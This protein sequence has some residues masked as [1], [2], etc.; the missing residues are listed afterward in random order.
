MTFFYYS[1]PRLRRAIAPLA[2]LA[3]LAPAGA[4]QAQTTTFSYT[5]GL[6]TYTVPAG[7]TSLRVVATGA[8]GGLFYDASI[9]SYSYGGRVQATVAVTPGEVLTVRVGGQGTTNDANGS[10]VFAGGFNGGGIGTDDGSGSNGGGGGGGGATD[11]RRTGASTGDYLASR[12]ALLVAGGGGGSSFGLA[13]GGNGGTP[14][15]NDGASDS[16]GGSPGRGATQ[17]AVGAGTNG[18]YSGS[19]GTGGAGGN[20]VGGYS[21]GGGGG[22]YYGGGGSSSY[23][24]TTYSD[25]A[26]GGGGSSWAMAGSNPA[27]GVAATAGPGTLTITVAALTRLS[28]TFGPVGTPVTL[29]G[30]GLAG[31][32]G[33]RFNGTAATTFA[34]ASSTSIT[35]TVPAGA[36][37]GNV[38]VS[39]PSGTSNGLYFTVG[40]ATNN[41][42]SFD[43]TNDYVHTPGLPATS[44]FTLEA[45][46]NQAALSGSRTSLLMSDNAIPGALYLQFDQNNRLEFT[47]SGNSNGLPLTSALPIGQWAHVAVVYSAS[48]KSAIIYVN[49]AVRSSSNFI[50]AVPVAAQ[51][52][53]LGAWLNNGTPER[54]FTGRFDEVRLYS[55]ALTRAQIQADMYST[56]S[57][58]PAS[59]LAYYSFNQGTAGG[60]NAG[61]AGLTDQSSNGNTA[62]LTNF[63]LTGTASNYVRSFPTI[64]AISPARAQPGATVTVTG[65]NLL[66]ATSFAFNGTA[67]APFA[68][69]TNDLSTTVTVP[70]GTTTGPVSLASATLST[71]QGP[72]FTVGAPLPV[73]LVAFTAEAAG[74]GALLRWHTATELNNARFEVEASAD[75]RAFARVGTVAGAG[76]STQAH[77]YTFG[78]A[79]LTRY[80]A[81]LVYYRLR[82]V[83][84]DGTAAYSPV[85][86][87]AV[88][89]G[90]LALYPNPAA[91]TTT[92]SGAAAS[93]PVRV[94]DALGRLVLTAIT[95]AAG[96]A[97]LTLPA[98]QPA[99]LYLVRAGTA[100]A[101]RLVVE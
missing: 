85:R 34:V 70:T 36:T 81:P 26:G 19:A 20:N 27:Y 17:A 53:S 84:T 43:G 45:W 6:Q 73:Q 32:T 46:V 21:G 93:T 40:T 42:L 96:M 55:A 74:T 38:T 31:V 5:G 58:V 78:D 10:T 63:A 92:L 76:S 67:V 22:G 82:Q 60:A 87:V 35:A 89:G 86:P 48:T 28:P 30:F 98:S 47:V 100:P 24:N 68:T 61:A 12:N 66:D 97:P 69:P 37:S 4:A 64:T 16:G 29:T 50:T 62:T 71:Y 9:S 52:V 59:L 80:A 23:S 51:P 25:Y 72:T 2:V 1:L 90:R 33:V 39:T 57:A 65:T 99:G 83:D 3:V 79:D 41:A 7:V 75:G 101:L 54:F 13:N 56:T 11:L 8:S 44:E 88:G 15:G 14:N 77:A 49:G 18:A 95:D 94:Y 91:R